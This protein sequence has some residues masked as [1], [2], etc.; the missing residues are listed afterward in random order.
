MTTTKKH[1]LLSKMIKI[2]KDTT[3]VYNLLY[4][5][6]LGIDHFGG[7]SVKQ[8]STRCL[9]PCTNDENHCGR[10]SDRSSRALSSEPAHV[11]MHDRYNRVRSTDNG[12]CTRV[13]RY[14]PGRSSPAVQVGWP[15]SSLNAKLLETD[16]LFH[17]EIVLRRSS[18]V[19]ISKRIA[20]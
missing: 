9:E 8:K 13:S 5:E 15:L 3:S 18:G 6:K 2:T 7:S 12:A 16:P 10:E 20:S 17:I 14:L 4:F 11:D 19:Y 1:T